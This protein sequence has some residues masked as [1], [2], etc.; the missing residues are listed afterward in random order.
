MS[1]LRSMPDTRVVALCVFVVATVLRLLAVDFWSDMGVSTADQSEY[2]ALAKYLRFHGVLSYGAPHVWGGPGLLDSTGPFLPTAARP[3]LYPLVIAALWWGEAPPL[4]A[5]RVL[6]AVLGGGVALLVYLMALRAFDR[7]SALLSGMAMALA[8]LSTFLVVHILSETLFVFLLTLGL[9]LWG[10][11]RWVLAGIVLGAATLTRAVL[12]PMFAAIALL[13]VLFR[14]NRSGHVRLL[15]AAVL[16]IAPWTIRNV[17]TQ[18]AVIP[19]ASM[20]WGANLFLG[21]FDIPYNAG[22]PWLI[23]NKDEAFQRIIK[24]PSETEAE[25][26]FMREAL[27]RIAEDPLHWAYVRLKQYPRLF[28]SSGLYLREVVPVPEQVMRLTYASAGLLF[29]FL[30]IAGMVLARKAWRAVYH[31]A[32]FPIILCVAQFPAV[33]EERYATQISPMLVIFAG[34]AVSTLLARRRERSAVKSG[35]G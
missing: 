6:Q 8:P 23:V 33:G 2:L 13:A 4:P 14:F 1:F 35:I 16:V 11:K 28:L 18:H 25:R 21:L 5:I 32:L 27:V 17:V 9:W 3:P 24:I 34:Y 29:V 31:L 12:L 15:L 7:R 10:G 30:S 20:G 26:A 19:V 22:N